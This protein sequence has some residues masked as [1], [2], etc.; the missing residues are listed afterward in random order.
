MHLAELHRVRNQLQE[1]L[2]RHTGQTVEQVHIDMQRDR[3]FT[4]E[5]AK[6]YG[7]VDEVIQSRKLD[8]LPS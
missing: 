2:A 4:A 8:A 1:L 7:I 3:I 6:A 5:E